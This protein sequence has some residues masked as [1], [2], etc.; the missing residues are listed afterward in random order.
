MD[1]RTSPQALA[2]ALTARL[3]PLD[4]HFRVHVLRPGEREALAQRRPPP[5]AAPD[6]GITRVEVLA[7]ST[8]VP[9][10]RGFPAFQSGP[11]DQPP[12]TPSP[13]TPRPPPPPH[14]GGCTTHGNPR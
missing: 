3:K 9:G 12:R 13:P 8:S 10:L 6:N 5:D 14:E 2:E 1:A 7:G 4:R 11:A